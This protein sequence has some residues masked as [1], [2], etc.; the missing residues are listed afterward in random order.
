MDA[1]LHGCLPGLARLCRAFQRSPA[2]ANQVKAHMGGP[3]LNA[4][5]PGAGFGQLDG[6]LRHLRLLE[7]AVAGNGLD[8]MAIAIA[9]EEIHLPVNLGG[10]EAQ[11]PIDLAHGLD[12]LAPVQGAQE[13]Q[14]VD[15]VTDGDLVGGLVLAFEADQ[16]LDG[17]SLVREP[18]LQPGPRQVHRRA[19]AGQ[20]LRELRHEG[21]GQG[22]GGLRHVGHHDDEMR[23]TLLRHILQALDPQVSQVAIMPSDR[24]AGSDPAQ[25]FNQ[26]QPEHDRNGPQLAQLQ[27]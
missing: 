27:G 9:G 12:K 24:Q 1:P 11:R 18:V 22:Q 3:V 23:G 2:F 26:R 5:F 4:F 14:T 10:V 13:A 15:G 21:A 16:F 6:L 20:A 8:R 19:L 7:P 25:V 17:K